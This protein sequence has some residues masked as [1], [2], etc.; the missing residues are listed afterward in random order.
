MSQ[1]SFARRRIDSTSSSGSSFS[2]SDESYASSVTSPSFSDIEDS[3]TDFSYQVE[4][5]DD[6]DPSYQ[7]NIYVP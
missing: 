5:L 4:S 6:N 2:D 3:D 7:G 1:D